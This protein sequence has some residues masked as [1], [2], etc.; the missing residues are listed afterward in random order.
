M[1]RALLYHD[2]VPL[3]A[4]DSSGF[5][6][7]G[8]ARYKLSPEDFRHH[9]DAIT[10]AVIPPGRGSLEGLLLTIDDGGV[11][12]LS[13]MADLLEERGWR[14]HFFIT[15][16]RIGSRE[17]LNAEQIR[18]LDRRGHVIGSHSCSHPKRISDLA[19]CEIERE[20]AQSRLVLADILG[21]PVETASV[22]GGHYSRGVAR[23]AARAGVRTLFTSEPTT[24]KWE[25]DGCLILGRYTVFRGDG[26]ALAAALASGRWWPC[27]RQA[28]SWN[29]KKL[30]K[31]AGGDFYLACRERYLARRL[32]A[33]KTIHP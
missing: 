10:D 12:N 28:L 23:A 3:G 16:D 13:P 17:F 21:Q 26:P 27:W 9:L 31:R 24:K 8:A 14:G 7:P 25:I 4:E 19:E 1:V 22:P 6:G 30:A 20:W 33:G 2:V 5:P 32:H 18:E 29:L 11:S 15:T